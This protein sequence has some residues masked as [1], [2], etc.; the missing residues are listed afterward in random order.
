MPV[1][2]AEFQKKCLDKMQDVSSK[3]GRTVLFGIE[4]GAVRGV[5]GIEGG[6]VSG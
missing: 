1:G 6:V 5:V 4:P 3:E 2:D